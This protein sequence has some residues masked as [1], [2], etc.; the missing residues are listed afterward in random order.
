MIIII[1]LRLG[2]DV[3]L[4]P[5]QRNRPGQ[6]ARQK[7]VLLTG[8]SQLN[9]THKYHLPECR[10]WELLYGSEAKHLKKKQNSK[11]MRPSNKG[12]AVCY[13][14]ATKLLLTCYP[15]NCPVP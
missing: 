1:V 10:E 6:R 5:P 11:E 3:V 12:T 7:Y 15:M 2:I 9:M 13:G 14:E 8:I 4:L